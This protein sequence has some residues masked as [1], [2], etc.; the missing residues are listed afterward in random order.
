[1]LRGCCDCLYLTISN[2]R[3]TALLTWLESI[4]GKQRQV[5]AADVMKA[6]GAVL[7]KY[8]GFVMD[9][10]ML[11]RPKVEMKAVLKSLYRVT[12][13]PK[14]QSAL[15]GGFMSLADFQEGVGPD[16]VDPNVVGDDFPITGPNPTQQELEEIKRFASESVGLAK[17]DRFIFWQKTVEK[18]AS[19][20]EKEWAG[21]LNGDPI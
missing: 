14:I 5:T 15:T 7:M 9:V 13:D 6:Y 19:L 3:G 17:L 4:F 2:K 18:E 16:P 12:S 10:S 1:M 21:F 20:L 11:P 8:P